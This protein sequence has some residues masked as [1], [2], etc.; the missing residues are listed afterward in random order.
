MSKR[1][2][3]ALLI[4]SSIAVCAALAAHKKDIPAAPLPGAILNAKKIFVSNGGGSN[5]AFDALYTR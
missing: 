2:M 1:I 5:L 4:R 3:S